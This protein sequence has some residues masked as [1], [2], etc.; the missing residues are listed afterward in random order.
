[1]NYTHGETIWLLAME[2]STSNVHTIFEHIELVVEIGNTGTVTAHNQYS[3]FEYKS[4]EWVPIVV[5]GRYQLRGYYRDAMS[6]A[7]EYSISRH[8]VSENSHMHLVDRCENVWPGFSMP[9]E[10]L[11]SL[12]TLRKVA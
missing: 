8:I 11:S 1:V 3:C 12:E 2:K 6:V 7:S 5:V 4:G 10:L 9:V